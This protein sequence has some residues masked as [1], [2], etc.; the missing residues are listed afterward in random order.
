MIVN[1]D[2]KKTPDGDKLEERLAELAKLTVR[3]GYQRGEV[4][5]DSEEVE[6]FHKKQRLKQSKKKRSSPK[7][8][9]KM[10]EVHHALPGVA[11]KPG[12]SRRESSVDLCDVVMWNELG[13]VHS[14][15]RPF[16]RMSVDENKDK[17]VKYV[18]R[19]FSMFT[20]FK[21]D[22]KQ[23]LNLLGNYQVGLI[24][25][26]IRDGKFEPNSPYT[27]ARKGSDKPL[28]DTG[29]MRQSVHYQIMT[30]DKSDEL[31]H[32]TLD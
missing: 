16:L 7:T 1:V 4:V 2:V 19:V 12:A 28:I 15:S 23:L 27:I 5:Y 10:A 25:R 26:K 21:I 13:T 6:K 32:E 8:P 22:T 29:R 11:H 14:P 18:K 17:I 30:K 9:K 24:Q 20:K 3:V 31:D